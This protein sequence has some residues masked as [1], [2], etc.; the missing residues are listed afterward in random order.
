MVGEGIPARIDEIRD[1]VRM[2]IR[3]IDV[4]LMTALLAAASPLQAEIGLP[5]VFSDH[6]VLQRELPIAVWGTAGPDRR[7]AAYS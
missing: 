2:N 3:N 5:S 6:M 1:T 7:I 4:L